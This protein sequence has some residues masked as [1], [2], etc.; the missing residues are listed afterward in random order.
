M[1]E[2]TLSSL[3][4]SRHASVMFS[5]QVNGKKTTS[6][7]WVSPVIM[8]KHNFLKLKWALSALTELKPPPTLISGPIFTNIGN[9]NNDLN[10]R[11]LYRRLACVRY[12][13]TGMHV[14]SLILNVYRQCPREMLPEHYFSTWRLKRHIPVNE[15]YCVS[16]VLTVL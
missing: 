11:G 6:I 4:S 5:L 2:T 1:Q 3:L 8:M 13:K 15:L 16:Y 14:L 10:I 9:K 12:Q 7:V